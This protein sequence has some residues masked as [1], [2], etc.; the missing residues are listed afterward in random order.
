LLTETTRLYRKK[1]DIENAQTSWPA[2]FFL[3]HVERQSRETSSK[4][5]YCVTR[6]DWILRYA[7]NDEDAMTGPFALL[8]VTRVR[9]VRNDEDAT[10]IPNNIP[11]AHRWSLWAR[12]C[13]A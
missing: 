10:I 7:Q 9:N 4:V 5:L 3:R 6:Y 2:F 11:G 12:A 13:A 1:C 8:R